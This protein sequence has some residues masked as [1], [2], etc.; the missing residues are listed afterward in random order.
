M[1]YR[2]YEIR[3]KNWKIQFS[4][5]FVLKAKKKIDIA[6]NAMQFM[7]KGLEFSILLMLFGKQEMVERKIPNIRI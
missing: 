5:T 3:P 2:E 4:N 1:Q 6:V 7:Y